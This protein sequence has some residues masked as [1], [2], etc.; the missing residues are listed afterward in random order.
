MNDTEST[1][2]VNRTIER[3][4]SAHGWPATFGAV[5]LYWLDVRNNEIV[6]LG[7]AEWDTVSEAATQ[8]DRIPTGRPRSNVQACLIDDTGIIADKPIAAHHASALLGRSF[9]ALIAAGRR[10]CREKA[11]LAI[12]AVRTRND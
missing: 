5:G 11:A 2:M 8:F 10:T 7:G 4:N 1:A 9:R 3:L 6:P 12:D